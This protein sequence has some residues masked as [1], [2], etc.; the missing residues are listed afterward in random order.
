M[1]FL[2]LRFS[3]IIMIA[4]FKRIWHLLA[5]FC[6]GKI[7]RMSS[8]LLSVICSMRSLYAY[9]Y[10]QKKK[11]KLHEIAQ[12]WKNQTGIVH[13]SLWVHGHPNLNLNLAAN[14]QRR[15]PYQTRP[16]CKIF[17]LELQRYKVKV[18]YYRHYNF[19]ISSIF[20]TIT[21][22]VF[23]AHWLANFYQ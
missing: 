8:S 3:L 1:R 13:T 20:F 5:C 7:S 17:F 2:I 15:Q 12:Q 21:E 10:V 19:F 6:K 22:W 16:L 11:M 9:G 14:V 23:L 4:S 18:S